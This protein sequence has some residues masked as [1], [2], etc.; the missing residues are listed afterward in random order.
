LI[1]VVGFGVWVG[2]GGGGGVGVGGVGGVFLFVRGGG[3]VRGMGEEV[4][5][6][7]GGPLA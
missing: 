3:V 7:L 6:V 5:G 4:V 1:C 2:G